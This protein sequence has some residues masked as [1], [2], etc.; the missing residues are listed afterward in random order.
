MSMNMVII[1][2]PKPLDIKLKVHRRNKL[3]KK[4]V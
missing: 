2:L 3:K 1:M 4:F